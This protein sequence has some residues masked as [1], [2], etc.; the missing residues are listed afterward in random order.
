MLQTQSLS[1]ITSN[2]E[3]GLHSNAI[4]YTHIVLMY[5]TS[6]GL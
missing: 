6:Q 3:I 5:K 4:S 1:N 2:F